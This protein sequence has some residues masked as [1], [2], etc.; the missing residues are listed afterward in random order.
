MVET[1]TFRTQLVA[2]GSVSAAT[3]PDYALITIDNSQGTAQADV[4]A[5]SV[6]T[7]AGS[8]T[9]YDGDIFDWYGDMGEDI[10]TD[11][12]NTGVAIG[13]ARIETCCPLP[14]ARSEALV[15]APDGPPADITRLFA[16]VGYNEP[17][18]LTRQP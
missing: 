4:P 15:Y 6:V 10:S 7:A 18:Q 12:Y 5:L 14:G 9:R 13:N 8:T 16:A 3:V 2:I 17:E 11:L 1:E